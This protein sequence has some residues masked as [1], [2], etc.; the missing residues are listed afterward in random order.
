MKHRKVLFGTAIAAVFLVACGGS[1]DTSSSVMIIGKWDA[2]M[3]GEV[4]GVEFCG[5]GTVIPEGEEQ[6]RY[7]V[8]EGDPDIIQIT[9]MDSEYISVELE[10]AFEDKDHCTL[11]A[12]GMT[13]TLTRIE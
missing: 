4:R 2:D 13:V 8:I 6:Q 1:V 10:L 11:S 12:D 9:P 7:T 3:M 5:D